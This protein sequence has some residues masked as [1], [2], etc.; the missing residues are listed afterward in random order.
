MHAALI[1]VTIDPGKED[2]ARAMLD[3][4]VVPMVRQAAGFVAA[5]WLE[6]HDGKALSIAVFDSEENAKAGAPPAGMRPPGSP[7]FVESVEFH[8]VMANA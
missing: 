5:Y 1:T 2:E 8:N 6:P 3:A 7:V 4:Q